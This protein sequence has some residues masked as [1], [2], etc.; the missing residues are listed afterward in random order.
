[1]PINLE[2]LWPLLLLA[3]LLLLLIF[4]KPLKWLFSL[5][6]RSGVG[7]VFL[8]LWNASGLLPGLIL[9]A[10]CFNAL[11]LGLLGFPGLALLLLLRWLSFT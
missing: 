6:L 7:L 11:T 3:A 2:N 5:A 8:T 10:N 9:G 4:R 1:M